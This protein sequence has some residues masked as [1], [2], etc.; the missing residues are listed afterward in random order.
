MMRLF[1]LILFAVTMFGCGDDGEPEPKRCPIGDLAAPAEAELFF[2]DANNQLVAPTATGEVPLMI[3]PQG[4]WIVLVGVRAR[5]IDGCSPT[6][7]TA[8]VDTD[9]GQIL[10]IDQ[11]QTELELD[12]SGWGMSRASTVGNLQVCPQLTATRDLYGQPY[13]VSAVVEDADGNKATTQMTVT[14]TCPPG[15]SRCQCECARDYV[16][17]DECPATYQPTVMPSGD[18]SRRL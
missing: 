7:T 15:E 18:V 13:V 9:D 10:K 16:V 5:N 17:G 1:S 3:P 12:A 6:L 14:P 4:G 8:L 2:L 11:R